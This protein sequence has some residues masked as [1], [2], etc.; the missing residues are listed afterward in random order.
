MKTIQIDSLCELQSVAKS[1]VEE[2]RGRN[3]VLFRGGMSSDKTTLISS[4]VEILGSDDI[5]TSPTF[6]IINQYRFRDE[7]PIY[8][9]AMSRLHRVEEA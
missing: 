5:V 1:V 9:F 4:I 2:L 3:V 8:H 6:A 7:R